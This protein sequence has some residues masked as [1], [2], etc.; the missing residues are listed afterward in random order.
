MTHLIIH[1]VDELKICRPISTRWCYSIE[2]HLLVLKRYVHNR[3]SSKVAWPPG[4]CMMKLLGF[5]LNILHGTP[6]Q[7]NECGMQIKRKLIVGKYWLV[8]EKSKDLTQEE[9]KL[10]H[11]Y[12][13][14]NSTSMDVAHR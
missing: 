11:E 6:T 2:R 9:I 10:I 7:D 5:A 12:V 4:T 1:V 13:I 3:L 14:T 8:A